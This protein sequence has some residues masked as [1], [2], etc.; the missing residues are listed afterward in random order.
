M[1]SRA[2]RI[3][4]EVTMEALRAGAVDAIAKPDT[5]WGMG[6]TPFED[7]L[8]SKIRAAAQVPIERIAAASTG[9]TAL[10]AAGSDRGRGAGRRGVE[11]GRDPGSGSAAGS[12]G[13]A[14]TLDR[15]RPAG[16]AAKRLIVIAT[17]TG[18]PRALG[19]LFAGLHAPVDAAVIVIQHMLTGFTEALAERLDRLGDMAVS[20]AVEDERLLSGR[21]LLAPAIGTSPSRAPAGSVSSTASG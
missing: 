17:S 12:A 2:T 6:P 7:E 1:L 3:G 20:E 18:G 19:E 8:I 11:A 16:L 9:A 15:P 5:A 10:P 14:A 13:G 21:A 4:A